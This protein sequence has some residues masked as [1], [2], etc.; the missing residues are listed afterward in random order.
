MTGYRDIRDTLLARIR[1]GE[2]RPGAVLPS[3]IDLASEFGVARATVSKAI[4][5]LAADGLVERRRRAG[6]TVAS[7][8]VRKAQVEIVQASAEIEAAG[9]AYSYRLIS[10][11]HTIPEH[12]A[13]KLGPCVSLLCLHLA[14]GSPWQMEERW[15]SVTAVPEAAPEVFET[16]PPGP[17]LIERVPLTDA[18]FCFYASAL[19]PEISRELSHPVGTAS[20]V[21]ERTT[22]LSEQPITIARMWHTPG[23]Q[24]RFSHSP[25]AGSLAG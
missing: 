19:P 10:A 20:F 21:S 11:A 3:E 14:D 8:P 18:A 7:A 16:V 2:L 5:D 25:G 15:I 9:A 24:M 17:W 22:W 13:A 4:A 1:K 6:T 12:V 23:Y